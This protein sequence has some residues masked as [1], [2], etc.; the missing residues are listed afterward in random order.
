MGAKIDVVEVMKSEL[1]LMNNLL[2]NLINIEDLVKTVSEKLE[3]ETEDSI[4][5]F[6]HDDEA[7]VT[8]HDVDRHI[9]SA[10][11]D[12][13]NWEDSIPTIVYETVHEKLGKNYISNLSAEVQDVVNDMREYERNPLAY[14]GMSQKDFL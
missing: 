14:Y 1:E 6:I 3:L 12:A 11:Q 13:F 9:E 7:F 8:S 2:L 10:F 4:E 5:N